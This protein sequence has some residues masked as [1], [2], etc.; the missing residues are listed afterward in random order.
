MVSYTFEAKQSQY[1]DGDK[2]TF[3]VKVSDEDGDSATFN[4]N[5]SMDSVSERFTLTSDT[6][7]IDGGTG[8][9]ILDLDGEIDLGSI[10]SRIDNIEEINLGDNNSNDT[11][12]IDLEDVV[13]MTDDDNDLVI[14]GD[15]GDTINLD[16]N[17]GWQRS[18]TTTNIDGES[19]T[20]YTN[21]NND[22]ISVFIDN[23]LDTTGLN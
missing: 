15:N 14:K 6:A 4:L 11:I 3:E 16:E 8:Y 10:A 9:D 20:E 2:E 23:D 22:T 19:F 5:I 13:A 17:D 1:D 18:D 12:H 21:T 7:T